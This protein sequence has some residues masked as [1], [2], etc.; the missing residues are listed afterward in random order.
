MTEK[1]QSELELLELA[2]IG[3]L[4]VTECAAWK[5]R[6][7]ARNEH[8]SFLKNYRRDTGE[9]FAEDE[10][11]LEDRARFNELLQPAQA[12]QKLLANARAATRRAV[13]RALGEHHE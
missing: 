4:A 9:L 1:K 2:A 3:R 6:N 11:E 8:R 10:A 12:A 7:D 13:T 5:A